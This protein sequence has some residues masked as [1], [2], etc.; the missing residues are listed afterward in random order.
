MCCCCY[1]GLDVKEL[2]KCGACGKRIYCSAECQKKDWGKKNGQNHKLFCGLN[3]GEE[4]C[5]YEIRFISEVVGYGVFAKVNIQKGQRIMVER[6]IPLREIGGKTGSGIIDARNPFVCLEPQSVVDAIG[7]LAPIGADLVQKLKTNS[8]S[9]GDSSDP[10]SGS[11]ICM[12]MSRVNHRCNPNADHYFIQQGT[13]DGFATGVISLFANHDIAAGEQIFISYCSAL[14]STL[15][16]GEVATQLLSRYGIRCPPECGCSD[17]QFFARQ[18]RVNELDARVVELA[19]S[20]DKG[21]P[22]GR[23]G[24]TQALR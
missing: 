15:R 18:R 6:A 9:L 10:D 3:C 24:V 19:Q 14:Q 12:R 17:P 16:D 2:K 1:K 22:G 11:G 13:H 21:C 20:G 5:E 4:N 23:K 7:L 8:F